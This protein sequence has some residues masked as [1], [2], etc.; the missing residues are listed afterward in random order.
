MISGIGPVM[1][2]TLKS[3]GIQTWEQVAAF[4]KADIAKVTEAI[5]AFPGR[6]ERDDWVGGAKALLARGHN[7]GESTSRPAALKKSS[8]KKAAKKAKKKTAKKATATAPAKKT[9]K[10][11][12]KKA[13][14]T[15]SAKKAPAKKASSA[16]G[17]WRAGTTKLGTAGAAHRDD[18]KV[19]N[20]I[21]PV[22]EKTLNG[23]GINT[24]EQLA[25]FSK[26]D[27]EKVTAAIDA[28]PGRIERDEWVSQAGD[29]VKRF[30][31][32]KPYDRPTRKTFLNN[33]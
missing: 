8:A 2:R 29:L 11:V 22:M 25:A 14:A 18:L 26:A 9:A 13:T 32:N 10:Q 30:P 27:V 4:T 20:G 17:S 31:L 16:S 5:D 12:A 23:F 21:G 24:W 3:F 33:A 15:A 7:P 19:V 28:F 1:E 6:I